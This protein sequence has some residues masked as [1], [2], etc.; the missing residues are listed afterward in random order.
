MWQQANVANEL[1]IVFG[2]KT[3]LSMRKYNI[4]AIIFSLIL[5]VK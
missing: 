5:K 4:V 2:S 3:Y 1:L